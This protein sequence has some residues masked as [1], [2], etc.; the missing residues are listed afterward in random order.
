MTMHSV[1][2]LPPPAHQAMRRMKLLALVSGLLLAGCTTGPFAT[3][4]PRPERI[5]IDQQSLDAEEAPPLTSVPTVAPSVTPLAER[6]AL[7]QQLQEDRRRGQAAVSAAQEADERDGTASDGARELAAVIQ[8]AHGS[9]TLDDR[10][11]DIL[12][13]VARLQQER[14]NSLLVVGHSSAEAGEEENGAQ[15]E[16]NL[17]MSQRRADAVAEAL[18]AAGVVPE[19]LQIQALGDRDLQYEETAPSGEAGNRRVEIFLL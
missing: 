3:D 14:G 11:Q 2:F 18:R 6:Q 16:A 12:Q 19:A 15:A 10:D 7:Q 4:D 5:P 13:Q 9:A 8:F 1:S 17:K